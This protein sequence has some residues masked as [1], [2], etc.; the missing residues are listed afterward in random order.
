LERT[1]GFSSNVL[2]FYCR[3]IKINKKNM[4][5][6]ERGPEGSSEQLKTAA[7]FE[8]DLARLEFNEKA[9]AD[10]MFGILSQSQYNAYTLVRGEVLGKLHP[11]SDPMTREQ[12]D[13]YVAKQ[14]GKK[15]LEQIFMRG[16]AGLAKEFRESKK[17]FEKQKEMVS[18]YETAKL[19]GEEPS[20]FVTPK[21]RNFGESGVAD[22]IRAAGEKFGIKGA[23]IFNKLTFEQAFDSGLVYSDSFSASAKGAAEY[24]L[25]WFEYRN[26][27]ERTARLERAELSAEPAKGSPKK[28]AVSGSART[29]KEFREGTGKFIEIDE[30]ELLPP[31][32]VPGVKIAP[33]SKKWEPVDLSRVKPRGGS[34]VP[35]EK[36]KEGPS[37]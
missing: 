20:M 36:T 23:D 33:E 3:K 1:C 27:S 35:D 19:S 5:N 34:V 16:K 9:V 32:K 8:R 12:F 14:G 11:E 29:G 2:Q 37:K 10:E 30:N 18:L 31:I 6:I 7:T 22:K 25:S 17:D 13:A 21:D 24:G 15:F 4:P 26:R 28:G